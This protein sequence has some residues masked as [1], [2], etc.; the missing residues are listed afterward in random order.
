LISPSSVHSIVSHQS[1]AGWRASLGRAHMNLWPHVTSRNRFQSWRLSESLIPIK[2]SPQGTANT[3]A[4]GICRRE[5][6]RQFCLRATNAVRPTSAEQVRV[7]RA[8]G[9]HHPIL[10]SIVHDG[11]A[12]VGELLMMILVVVSIVLVVLVVMMVG[13]D[14]AHY[15]RIARVD[16]VEIG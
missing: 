1:Q 4:V 16:I 3:D 8:G 13:V 15:V 7:F 14:A 9:R 12:Q 6:I 5:Q 2:A 10:S 11:V